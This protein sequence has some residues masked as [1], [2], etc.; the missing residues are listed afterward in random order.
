MKE[1]ILNGEK[2]YDIK[3]RHIREIYYFL[4]KDFP[5]S[6]LQ[7]S[8]DIGIGQ[9]TLKKD[10]NTISALLKSV[11]IELIRKPRIGVYIKNTAK[12]Q[13]LR[14]NKQLKESLRSY[15]TDKVNFEK[16][17]RF[18]K[19]LFNFLTS[20]KIPSV[21]AWSF[22]LNAS[23]T[24]ILK[25]I[26]VVKSWLNKR[27]VYI[28]SKPGVGYSIY[29]DEKDIRNALVN[30]LFKEL[31]SLQ[32][33]E[34]NEA[35][36]SLVLLLTRY[37]NNTLNNTQYI[38]N[39][40]DN[41]DLR[42]IGQCIE[43]LEILSN[44]ELLEE[45]ILKFSIS[46]L[47]SAAR[48][49]KGHH[50]TMKM[51]DLKEAKKYPEYN[52]V[53]RSLSLV[54]ALKNITTSPEEIA[55]ITFLYV[56]SEFVSRRKH[57]ERKSNLAGEIFESAEELL[58]IPLSTE[59]DII[60]MCSIHIESTIEKLKH[61]TKIENPFTKEIKS[62]H[63]ICFAVASYVND[64]T[65]RK[66]LKFK[67]P[68]T[69]VTFLTSYIAAAIEKIKN[70][71]RKKTL[72]VVC[73][74]NPGVFNFILYKLRNEFPDANII[75]TTSWTKLFKSKTYNTLDL[76]ISSESLHRY[77]GEVP[78]IEI[79]ELLS[80]REIKRIKEILQVSEINT[81]NFSLDVP[82]NIIFNKADFKSQREAIRFLVNT[83]L[84]KEFIDERYAKS[85]IEQEIAGFL[86]YSQT[87]AISVA[88]IRLT[89]FIPALN[90]GI[91]IIIFNSPITF[92]SL[93]EGNYKIKVQAV[94]MPV[95]K[96]KKG[97]NFKYYDSLNRFLR[98]QDIQKAKGPTT[99]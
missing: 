74:A 94:V 47:V 51:E 38:V 21:E 46:I 95:F 76:I 1:I 73:S 97:G 99:W 57:G 54:N 70:R 80:S 66:N 11:E 56:S 90:N 33:E 86:T 96:K 37:L 9:R 13:K 23:R 65:I 53:Q 32:T 28:R 14:V 88:L 52:Y 55:Y 83:L 63:P 35:T 40:L 41:L 16:N 68:E 5:V 42:S 64:S 2:T 81:N 31:H 77:G 26:K 61:N 30:F 89:K 8:K 10:L 20:D 78:M 72:A 18:K 87:P 93:S 60:H 48:L 71:S 75:S 82:K 7:A 58:G 6:T 12:K 34:G 44:S 49:K 15:G 85:V 3:S 50:I 25:D 17:E 27:N 45:E 84:K 39:T 91:G 43:N 24:T 59:T 29:G 36:P 22:A 98:E 4:G 79:K 67:F 92:N 62:T 19:I 69:E